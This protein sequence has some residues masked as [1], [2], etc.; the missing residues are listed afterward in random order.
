MLKIFKL[1]TRAHKAKKLGF[2]TWGIISAR[3]LPVLR[4]AKEEEKD[5]N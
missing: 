3:H 2:K 1:L 4:Y 5:Q